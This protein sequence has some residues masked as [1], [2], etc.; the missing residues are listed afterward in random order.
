MLQA[1]NFT[2]TWSTTFG[3]LKLIHEG[4]TVYG[5][6]GTKGIIDA[7]QTG[8]TI[9]GKFT[10]AG[11]VGV[12]YFKLAS[13]NKSFTGEWRWQGDTTNRGNWTG[14]LKSDAFPSLKMDKWTGKYEFKS[15]PSGFTKKLNLQQKGF[16]LEG[17][18][19]DG[20]SFI[21]KLSNDLKTI[22]NASLYHGNT[23][24]NITTGIIKS[25]NS[26]HITVWYG[27]IKASNTSTTTKFSAKFLKPMT[28]AEF[29]S[30]TGVSTSSTTTYKTDTGG[31]TMTSQG[32][33][34]STSITTKTEKELRYR[35]TLDRIYILSVEDGP[36]GI[37]SGYELYGIAWCR[38]YDS[39]GKQIKPFDVTYSDQYGR[40]WEIKAKD[41]I[42]TDLK[43][44]AQYEINKKITFDI[45]IDG[46]KDIQ[47]VLK[48]S[49]IE[50]TVEL[51]D[52]DS[53]SS[54]DILGKERVTLPLN[55]ALIS[56]LGNNKL[57]QP[58]QKGV[59]NIKHGTRG[60]IMVTFYIEKI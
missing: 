41:Y 8:S 36:E 24:Y 23:L 46:S 57:P 4:R 48:K 17:K 12:F 44:G 10:N 18:F 34:T 11:K 6:Y 39:N 28:V 14:T 47:E 58:T 2:G 29:K 21:G 56:K 55:E 20:K 50:L 15:Y 13:D 42:R 25:E 30:L 38:A 35:L 60:H 54:N 27:D 31:L 49:K 33:G 51:K 32:L 1:Q 45:P 43:V 53:A 52:Y 26:E 37:F 3:D 22:S 7:I 59:I 19:E 16:S 5:D 40:F 9:N